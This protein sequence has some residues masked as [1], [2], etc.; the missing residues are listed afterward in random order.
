MCV[1]V[2]HIQS[3]N[4]SEDKIFAESVLVSIWRQL[5][6]LDLEKDVIH[7]IGLEVN[8]IATKEAYAK[9]LFLLPS[10]FCLNS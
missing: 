8:I 10:A 6:K 5:K 7:F 4:R 1:V 2:E 9:S 3:Y